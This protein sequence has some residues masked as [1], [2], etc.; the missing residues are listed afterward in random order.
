MNEGKNKN[1]WKNSVQC[2]VV[3][4]RTEIS[5]KSTM[6]VRVVS[7]QS[8][9]DNNRRV[10]HKWLYK[11]I[12]LKIKI[13]IDESCSLFR[14]HDSIDAFLPR[15]SDFVSSVCPIIEQV[16]GDNDD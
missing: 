16:A 11:N 3:Y 5:Q 14:V 9:N 13:P 7:S 6:Y 12:R 2:F 4:K 1:R 10:Y 15:L 8:F